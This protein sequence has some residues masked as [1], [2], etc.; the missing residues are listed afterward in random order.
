MHGAKGTWRRKKGTSELNQCG[1][2]A[3]VFFF[4]VLYCTVTVVRVCL[5]TISFAAAQTLSELSACV[6]SFNSSSECNIILY[7]GNSI[8]KYSTMA[9]ATPATFS[10]RAIASRTNIYDISFLSSWVESWIVALVTLTRGVTTV[11]GRRGPQ[12][13]HQRQRRQVEGSFFFLLGVWL[14]CPLRQTLFPP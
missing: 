7:I 3:P 12:R 11:R 9:V 5:L 6:R 8:E 2:D 14:G 4:S 13:S 10:S 1:N